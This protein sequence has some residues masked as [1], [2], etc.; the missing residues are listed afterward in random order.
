MLND[1]ISQ[2]NILKVKGYNA[3][4][5]LQLEKLQIY[6]TVQRIEEAELSLSWH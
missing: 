5:I 3:M 4:E 1:A 2:V 6:K